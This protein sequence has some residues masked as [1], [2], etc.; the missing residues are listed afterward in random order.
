M[1]TNQLKSPFKFLNSYEKEDIDIFFG[2]TNEVNQLYQAIFKNKLVLMYGVTGVGKTSIIKCGLANRF[3]ATQWFDLYLRRAGMPL[4]QSAEIQIKKAVEIVQSQAGKS[5]NH[6][7]DNDDFSEFLLDNNTAHAAQAIQHQLPILNELELLYKYTF[8]PIY[9]IF[10]QLEEI[11]TIGTKAEQVAFFTFLRELQASNL[12]VKVILSIREEYLAYVWDFKTF[13][14]S[15]FDHQLHIHKIDENRLMQIIQGTL[16][17]K[18]I[19]TQESAIAAIIKNIVPEKRLGVELSHLQIYLDKLYRES[20]HLHNGNV[21]KIGFTEALV[22]EIGG[23]RGVLKGFLGERTENLPAHLSQDNL[24]AVLKKLITDNGT[25]RPLNKN[26]LKQLLWIDIIK[27]YLQDNYQSECQQIQRNKQHQLD[28]FIQALAAYF[29]QNNMLES[30][31]PQTLSVLMPRLIRY[32][33][34]EKEA[35]ID[36]NWLQHALQV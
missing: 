27:Q 16:Q 24:W 4:V 33:D 18:N 8:K 30:S 13:V 21:S 15:L 28:N 9:L 20:Y 35:E 7:L 22:H 34:D 1:N 2:R 29:M 25:K 3:D 17:K 23:I 32:H 5:T 31:L 6:Q 11:F 10:D 26:I 36:A 19:P 14:P 12:R